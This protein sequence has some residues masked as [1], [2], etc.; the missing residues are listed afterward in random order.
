MNNKATRKTN[1][2]PH[3]EE[4]PPRPVEGDQSVAQEAGSSHANRDRHGISAV[5]GIDE[6]HRE[7]LQDLMMK[8]TMLEQQNHQLALSASTEQYFLHR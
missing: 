7:T 3:Q 8:N 2:R 1:L 6:E 5:Q 4:D